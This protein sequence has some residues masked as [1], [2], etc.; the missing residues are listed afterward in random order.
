LKV[1]Q[2]Q[3]EK[4]LNQ[5]MDMTDPPEEYPAMTLSGE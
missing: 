4:M 1:Q 2:K 3:L 5:A